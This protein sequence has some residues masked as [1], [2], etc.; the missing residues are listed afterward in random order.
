MLYAPGLPDLEA[1]RL[2]CE[3]A[4]RPVNVLASPQFT[5]ADLAAAGA[6]RISLGGTLARV[7]VHAFLQA[8]RVIRDKGSFAFADNVP[9][10]SEITRGFPEDHGRS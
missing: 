3:T 2:V 7:A 1:V 9:P 10:F 5:V 8:A 6:A 4:S